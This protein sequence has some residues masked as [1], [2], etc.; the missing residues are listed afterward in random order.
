[1]DAFKKVNAA[2]S[3]NPAREV[4]A[5]D[6]GAASR[7]EKNVQKQK[8]GT[9][10]RNM[11]RKAL[12]AVRSPEARLSGMADDATKRNWGK[13]TNSLFDTKAIAAAT[14]APMLRK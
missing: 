11:T 3:G 7:V 1:M 5:G 9:A 8:L 12:D 4:G 10:A 14:A 2:L 13:F 6:Y